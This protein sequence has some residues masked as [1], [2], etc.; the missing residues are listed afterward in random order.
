MLYNGMI[1]PIVGFPI[2]GAIWYQGE[3]N[4]AKAWQ[5]HRLLTDM[6]R[7]WRWDWGQGDFPFLIAQLANYKAAANYQDAS[8]WARLREAQL[9]TLSEPAT[10]L[11]VTIDIGEAADIHPQNKTDVGRRRATSGPVGLVGHLRAAGCGIR[12]A[13][14]RNDPRRLNDPTAF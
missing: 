14:C 3:G 5:Y 12:P 11:A 13:V 10:G 9:Q 8:L 4:T 1:H 2:R 7:C 6:I